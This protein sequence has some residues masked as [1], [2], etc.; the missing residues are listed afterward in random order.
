MHKITNWRRLLACSD[1]KSMLTKFLV[2]SWKNTSKR[3]KLSGQVLYV[4]YED[5]CFIL[6]RE[7]CEEIPALRSSHEEADTRLFLHLKHASDNYSSLIINADDTDVFILALN[8]CN[9]IT[10]NIFI[11]RGTKCRMRPVSITELN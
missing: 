6:T 10:S 2:E 8:V 7:L 9:K 4:T 1:T 3:M 5:Q 11:R